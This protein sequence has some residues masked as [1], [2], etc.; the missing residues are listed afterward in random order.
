MHL[1]S[2]D[3]AHSECW[4][5]ENS[6]EAVEVR[7]ARDERFIERR[8]YFESTNKCDDCEEDAAPCERLTHAHASPCSERHEAINDRQMHISKNDKRRCEG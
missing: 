1:L 6:T 2:I 3:K 8:K 5:H 7:V 4:R